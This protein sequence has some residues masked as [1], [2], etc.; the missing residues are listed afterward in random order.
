[1]KKPFIY[2][3]G[4]IQHGNPTRIDNFTTPCKVFKYLLD[5]GIYSYVPHWSML[6]DYLLDM[7]PESYEKWMELDFQ[8]IRRC[9]GLLRLE[10]HSPG[11]DREVA[12]ATELGLPVFFRESFFDSDDP[13]AAPQWQGWELAANDAYNYFRRHWNA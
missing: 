12:L 4:A 2:I 3:A 10:G 11:A 8:I 7:G 6:F 13:Q 5:R 9:D 1:M